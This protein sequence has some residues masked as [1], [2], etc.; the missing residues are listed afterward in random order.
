MD[1]EDGFKIAH[2]RVWRGRGGLGG[3]TD[4]FRVSPGFSMWAKANALVEAG[5]ATPPPFLVAER[6]RGSVEWSC[7]ASEQIDAAIGLDQVLQ[8]A[9]AWS[10]A[11]QTNFARNLAFE[12]KKF[13]HQKLG[14]A[15][16]SP[17]TFLVRGVPEREVP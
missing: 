12:F 1:D 8:Q 15:E 5:I 14:V 11:R 9:A 4:R 16:L 3:M 13:R 6:R 17:S 7:F 10:E 2:V